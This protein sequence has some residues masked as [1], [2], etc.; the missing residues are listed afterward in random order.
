MSTPEGEKPMLDVVIPMSTPE[1]TL[2]LSPNE[3]GGSTTAPTCR[4]CGIIGGEHFGTRV[5]NG[6]ETRQPYCRACMVEYHRSWRATDEGRA[7]MRAGVRA[8]CERYPERERARYELRLALLRGDLAVGPC[9]VDGCDGKT[10]AHHDDYSKPLDVVWTCRAHH[11][12]L[13]RK[14]QATSILTLASSSVGSDT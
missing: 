6:R 8:S 10:E 3:D 13:D 5:R 2:Q 12:A 9:Y 4:R 7:K 14:R 11:R 1:A